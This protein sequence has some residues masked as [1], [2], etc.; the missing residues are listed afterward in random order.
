MA[1]QSGR[2]ALIFIIDGMKEQFPN[3]SI[4]TTIVSKHWKCGFSDGS[5]VT[6]YVPVSVFLYDWGND[7]GI[8]C[9]LDANKDVCPRKAFIYTGKEFP[10]TNSFNVLRQ[11]PGKR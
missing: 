6:R 1:T 8:L 2:L 9:Y 5:M 10:V 11:T 7:R 4:A 3:K